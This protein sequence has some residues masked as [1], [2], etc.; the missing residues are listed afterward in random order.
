MD[1]PPAQ[2]RHGV[3]TPRDGRE[4]DGLLMTDERETPPKIAAKGCA[5]LAMVRRMI[6]TPLTR[7]AM[8]GVI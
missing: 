6:A 7:L 4:G 3:E 1:C 8:G 2:D 5:F